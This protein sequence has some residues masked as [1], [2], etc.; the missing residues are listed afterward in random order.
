MCQ[1]IHQTVSVSQI[2]PAVRSQYAALFSQR[3]WKC[4]PVLVVTVQPLSTNHTQQPNRF[5]QNNGELFFKTVRF[6][7]TIHP[8][9]NMHIFP[10]VPFIL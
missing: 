8:K 7:A 6:T 9:S 1:D 10:V 2:L 3:V 5:S 4:V